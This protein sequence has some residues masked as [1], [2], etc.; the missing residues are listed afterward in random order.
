MVN[1]LSRA[2]VAADWQAFVCLEGHSSFTGA[3]QA[4]E[5]RGGVAGACLQKRNH[6]ASPE[7]TGQLLNVD[8]VA[9]A[10]APSADH[11]GR[12]SL[13][14]LGPLLLSNVSCT[15]HQ[16]SWT[17]NHKHTDSICKMK[18]ILH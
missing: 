12:H 13:H 8:S 5:K 16:K 11:T 18:G 7:P 6:L 17:F 3:D 2:G 1:G 14:L 9:K 15:R 4:A 10:H